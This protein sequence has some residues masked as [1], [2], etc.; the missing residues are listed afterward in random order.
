MFYCSRHQS[1]VPANNMRLS[2]IL[3]TMLILLNLT[4]CGKKGAL[5]YPDMLVPASPAAFSAMQSGNTIK[6]AF[7]IP[8]K[9]RAGRKVKDI[10]G[11]KVFKLESPSGQAP[12]CRDCTGYTHFKTLFSRIP[13]DVQI[14]GNLAVMLDG[15]VGQGGGYTYKAAAFT[16]EGVDGEAT[17][18]LHVNMQQLPQPPVLKIVP[19][20][21]E[22]RL[23][24]TGGTPADKNMLLGYNLYR[25]QKGGVWS[26]LPLNTKPLTE[27]VFTDRGLDRREKYL[28]VVKSIMRSPADQVFESLSSNEVEGVLK[29]EE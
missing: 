3:L 9:D 28:Y 13:G 29:D 15:N 21:T 1:Q 8:D 18:P 11:V 5:I 25:K 26:Y 16:G 4:A 12:V 24:F 27:T 23:E 10:V 20:P 22:L 14:Y 6:I 19:T 2:L 7:T 17:L